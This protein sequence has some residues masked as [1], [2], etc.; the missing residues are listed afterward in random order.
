MPTSI[1]LPHE[2]NIILSLFAH[3]CVRLLSQGAP[4]EKGQ[5]GDIGQPAID[6]FQAVKVFFLTIIFSSYYSYT[7]CL[8]AKC[9]LSS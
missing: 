4:G 2:T 9:T 6:V 3:V 5:K 8:F 7:L 1:C